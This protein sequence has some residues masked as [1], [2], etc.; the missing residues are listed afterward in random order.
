MKKETW[1]VIFEENGDEYKGWLKITASNLRK[2]PDSKCIII[3][4]NVMIEIDE[5]II[6]I[7]HINK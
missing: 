7:E 3:V 4:D 6:S 1:K 5:K 2:D